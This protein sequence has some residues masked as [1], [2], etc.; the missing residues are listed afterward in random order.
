M[1]D[2][3]APNGFGRSG[4]IGVGIAVAILVVTRAVFAFQNAEDEHAKSEWIPHGE[5]AAALLDYLEIA[6]DHMAPRL[7][8]HPGLLSFDDNVS[9]AHPGEKFDT[10]LKCVY[11]DGNIGDSRVLYLGYML[12][13]DDDLNTLAGYYANRMSNGQPLE[14]VIPLAKP[15]PDGRT[16]ILRIQLLKDQPPGGAWS[17]WYRDPSVI[18]V[19]IERSYLEGSGGH[20]VFLDGHTTYYPFAR[21]TVWP[22]DRHNTGPL[23]QMDDPSPDT[24]Q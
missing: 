16:A 20:V 22:C 14:D 6:P 11:P 19:F 8:M 18:P 5:L 12:E 1:A 9:P 21:S 10:V 17:N 2:E 23:R 24:K 13:D 15:R 7:S 3:S 4:A